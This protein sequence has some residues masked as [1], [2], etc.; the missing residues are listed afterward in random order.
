MHRQ[1]LTGSQSF[2]VKKLNNEYAIGLD[3]DMDAPNRLLL[4]IDSK[5]C[6]QFRRIRREL[7]KAGFTAKAIC[8]KRSSSNKWHVVIVLT[9]SLPDITRVALQAALGSDRW[10]ELCNIRSIRF[11]PHPRPKDWKWNVLYERKL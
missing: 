8:Y 1:V 7:R 10:R 4:D 6:P 9:V 3:S 5:R 11:P 2:S